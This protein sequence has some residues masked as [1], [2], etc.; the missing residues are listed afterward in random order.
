MENGPAPK[1][2][3]RHCVSTPIHT[4]NAV[5]RLNSIRRRA[6]NSFTRRR[7]RTMDLGP[8]IPEVYCLATAVAV[9][10]VKNCRS[11]FLRAASLT[12]KFARYLISVQRV[13]H[14]SQF[15]SH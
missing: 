12:D 10:H 13:R 11:F 2:T 7:W 5:S 14:D 3:K 8:A 6:W 1:T 15:P 4:K 9:S